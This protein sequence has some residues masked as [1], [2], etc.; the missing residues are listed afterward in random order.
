MI[1]PGN[2]R[3]VIVD[4]LSGLSEMP[5]IA[6]S[7]VVNDLSDAGLNI[8]HYDETVAIIRGL[9]E[10]IKNT[11]KDTSRNLAVLHAKA[12]CEPLSTR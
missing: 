7:K 4:A 9:L 2:S 1:L 12:L 5:Q 11:D 10:L 8:V 3:T 6:A